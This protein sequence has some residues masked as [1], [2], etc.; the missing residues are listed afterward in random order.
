MDIFKEIKKLDFP[1][2]KYVIVGSGP[3]AARGI[4]EVHDIDIVVT[5]DLFDK[6]KKEGWEIKQWTYPGTEGRI[7]LQNGIIEIYLGVNYGNF[8]PT[9]E[10]LIAR[11]NVI[12]N[13]PFATLED[14]IQFKSAYN[15]EKHLKDIELIK[16]YLNNFKE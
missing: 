6:L 13:I 14:I 3:M 7:Y 8:N 4:R 5:P 2:G 1:F 15:R 12:K 10:E 9:T 11:A 16:E